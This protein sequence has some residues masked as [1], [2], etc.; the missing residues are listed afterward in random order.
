MGPERAIPSNDGGFGEGEAWIFHAAK[1][2]GCGENQQV[3]AFPSVG[4]IKV[5]SRKKQGFHFAKFIGGLVDQVWHSI[6]GTPLAY[7]HVHVE[8]Y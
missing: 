2:E 4:T 5:F 6:D 3:I 8:L 1:W 7:V